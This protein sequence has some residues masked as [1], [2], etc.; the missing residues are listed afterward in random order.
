MSKVKGMLFIS[1][2]FSRAA[3]NRL[4]NLMYRLKIGSENAIT[5]LCR[6]HSCLA[7]VILSTGMN[8]IEWQR[9]LAH[10]DKHKVPVALL[11]T[12]NLY[13]TPIHLSVLA[14]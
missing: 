8:T 11:H 1:T 3:A 10:F 14:P 5:I 7:P 4:E 13:P 6:T 2:P 9:Q 12:T